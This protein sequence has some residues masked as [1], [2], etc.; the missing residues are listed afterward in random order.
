MTLSNRWG[1]IDIM[2]ANMKRQT[3]QD[4]ELIFVDAL[5]KEREK[6]V[7]EYINDPRLKY[8]RQNDKPEGA[9]TNLAH[10]DNQGFKA[11]EGDI[12]VCVQDYIWIPHDSLEKFSFHI[13]RLNNRAQITG[14]GHQYNKPSK[15]DMIDENGKI[16][17][18]K[19]PYT[20]RPDNVFWR[21]PR[22][23]TD[24]G[25]FYECMPA[26]IEYNYCAFPRKLVEDLGGM[27]EQFDFHGFAWDNVFMAVRG[28]M[29]G[30]KPYIDQT[31]ICMGFNHDGWWPNPLK[32]NGISPAKYYYDQIGKIQRGE[33][34][35]KLDYVKY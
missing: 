28:D 31:N 30:Y 34:S 8:I 5:W 3:E 9:Y 17:V 26:D 16:T 6:E 12:I 4:F 15:E 25:T 11:C 24:Q 13:S 33:I 21:D 10:A 14:V 35:I 22:M 29:L 19:E 18:F 23:R 20:K 2:W 1:G 32:M 27:D 7:K